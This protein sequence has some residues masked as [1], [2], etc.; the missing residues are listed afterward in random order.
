MLV[1]PYARVKRLLSVFGQV[2]Q[3]CPQ[4]PL[5]VLPKPLTAFCPLLPKMR[6]VLFGVSV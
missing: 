3:S 2:H 6:S 1:L 4:D 5:L